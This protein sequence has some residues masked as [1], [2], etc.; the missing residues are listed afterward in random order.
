MKQ[1][2]T[3]EHL[4]ELSEEQQDKLREWWT[5]AKGDLVVYDLDDDYIYTIT[6]LYSKNAEYIFH[7]VEDVP[8]A[9]TEHTKSKKHCLPLISIGQCIELLDKEGYPSLE[10][11]SMGWWTVT[12]GYGY[13]SNEPQ[14]Q[15]ELIDTLW[16][17]VKSVL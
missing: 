1:R 15:E 8:W 2:I 14:R 11:D 16:E 10:Q 4:L 7:D 13:G 17:A 6:C 12:F 5:P 9:E 3:V